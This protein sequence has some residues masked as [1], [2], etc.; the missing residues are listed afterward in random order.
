MTEEEFTFIVVGS[1]SSGLLLANELACFASTTS[2]GAHPITILLVELGDASHDHLSVVRS[3]GH[4]GAA[5]SCS[6]AMEN[7][8]TP[9]PDLWG[10]SLRCPVG[11]G[12]GGSS[13]INA[14]MW[15]PGA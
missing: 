13:N 8:S 7:I 1:G 14:M 2:A 10:R 4:W 5:A 3:A 15:T 11:T 6:A 12:V 9:Q